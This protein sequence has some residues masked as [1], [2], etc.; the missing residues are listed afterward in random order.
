MKQYLR[1]QTVTALL[2]LLTG[3]SVTLAWSDSTDKADINTACKLEPE[4]QC[5][6]AI[7]KG[8]NAPGLDMNHASMEK[9]RLDGAKLQRAN[10]S[11]A[12][13]QLANLK[14]ADL[15]LANLQHAHLHAANL[16]GA[17]L[18]M[19]NLQN[20]NLLDA[21][22]SGANL[23]GANLNG[24]ILIQAKFD[25]ATWTDGKICAKGSIGKCL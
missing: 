14:G 18:M 9:M 8:L 20:S 16:Q 4:A 17:N 5:T 15:M 1:L 12:I 3:T 2:L 7:R 25:G 13:M 10:F 21:D 19:A 11:Y 22:L 23:R 24:A 6:S